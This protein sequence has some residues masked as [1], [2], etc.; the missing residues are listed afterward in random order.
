MKK[1]FAIACAAL[2]LAGCGSSS[3]PKKET[4]TCSMDVQGMKASIKIDATDNKITNMQL[5]YDIPKDI[6]GTDASELSKDDLD[7]LG[8]AFVSK[9]GV[10]GKAGVS[11]KY[12]KNGADLKA[13]MNIDMSK[14]EGSTLK[15]LGFG[16]S[17]DAPFDKTIELSQKQGM[18]CK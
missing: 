11:A 6:T 9:M 17:K 10:K 16:D 7:T 4:K 1:L 5:V 13:T 3:E 12:E 18:T 14:V 8:D 15:T 2:L